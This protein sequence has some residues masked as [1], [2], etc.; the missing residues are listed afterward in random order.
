MQDIK[1]KNVDKIPL[2]GDIPVIGEYLFSHTTQKKVKTELLIFLTPHVAT[3]PEDLKIMSKQE[4]DGTKLLND[5]VEPG[6]F[7][8]HMEGMERGSA[9]PPATQPTESNKNGQK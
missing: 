9:H 7:Q 4:K 8:S 6:T 5:A 2:L 1:T 3:Q